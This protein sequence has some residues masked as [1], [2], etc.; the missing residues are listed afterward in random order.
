MAH[1][2]S[3]VART[4][5]PKDATTTSPVFPSAAGP[6]SKANEPE[7]AFHVDNG[8][9]DKD[10]EYQTNND[11]PEFHGWQFVASWGVDQ[12]APSWCAG[13]VGETDGVGLLYVR[14]AVSFLV[15]SPSASLAPGWRVRM[16]RD[17]A[18]GEE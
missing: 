3:N 14:Q 15:S 16:L 8:N 13:V 11:E 1:D 18:A 9:Q 12:A 7:N 4:R 6:L 10:K 5:I 2:P 17:R